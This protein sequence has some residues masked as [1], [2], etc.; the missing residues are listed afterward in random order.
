MEF[1]TTEETIAGHTMFIKPVWSLFSISNRPHKTVINQNGMPVCS[2]CPLRG[3]H[4]FLI[5]HFYIPPTMR[6]SLIK[7]RSLTAFYTHAIGVLVGAVAG[8]VACLVFGGGVGGSRSTFDLSL[9]LSSAAGT[10]SSTGG[11]SSTSSSLSSSSSLSHVVAQQQ[12][13]QQNWND[14][15]TGWSLAHIFYGTTTHLPKIAHVGND[16]LNCHTW[17]SQAHQDE[18]IYQLLNGK[19]NGYFVDLA[20]NDPIYLSNTFSLERFFGWNGLCIEANSMYWAGLSYRTCALVGAVV[21]LDRQEVHFRF[22]N[23]EL[24]G[25]VGD[26]FDNKKGNTPEQPRLTVALM[27]VLQRFNAPQMIDYLSLDVEGAE[28]MVLQPTVLDA[29]QFNLI[30]I[31]RPS[32][33]L[34]KLLKSKGYKNLKVLTSFGD[35]LFAHTAIEN[36]LNKTA[37]D[38]VD[39][40]NT[41]DNEPKKC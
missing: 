15:S 24:G 5:V 16:A 7:N 41:V 32:E 29:Y 27:E 14:K 4:R 30:T 19:H 39:T 20:A 34:Q 35:T 12:Q 8:W 6:V 9:L 23:K 2:A 25:I 33:S 18:L 11:G 36:Q 31:E 13:Q 3:K 37:L 28:D 1:C 38:T 17:F 10:S 40:W 22:S 26:Q 21:S